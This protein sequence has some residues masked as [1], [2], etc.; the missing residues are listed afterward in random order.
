MALIDDIENVDT[1]NSK[2]V[3]KNQ[4]SPLGG[5][6][7]NTSTGGGQRA[8]LGISYTDPN[9]TQAEA[10]IDPALA[11]AQQL[12]YER[13]QVQKRR[14]ALMNMGLIGFGS[15]LLGGSSSGIGRQMLLGA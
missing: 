15:N 11:A 9:P 12:D 10:P 4:R 6:G 7:Y 3:K 5:G 8:P 2:R 13:R 1:S 14:Q